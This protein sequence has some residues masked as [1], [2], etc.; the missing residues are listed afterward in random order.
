V[1]TER[2]FALLEVLIAFVIAAAALGVLFQAASGGGGAVRSAGRYEE[3]LS[4]VKSHMAALGQGGL[5][6]GEESGYDG[7]GY[8]WRIKI[9][10]V[11]IAAQA[12]NS[13]PIIPGAPRLTLYSIEAAV[14]WTV[15]GRQRE[16]VLHSQGLGR[17]RGAGNG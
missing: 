11:A 13:L 6:E 14:S 10:P 16:V 9:A 5:A 8:R 1:K 15:N 2:G 12:E 3:A 17:S 4:R 7:G